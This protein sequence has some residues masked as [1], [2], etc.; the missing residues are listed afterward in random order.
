MTTR[1]GRNVCQDLADLSGRSVHGVDANRLRSRYARAVEERQAKEAE[2]ENEFRLNVP[3]VARVQKLIAERLEAEASEVNAKLPVASVYDA[4]MRVKGHAGRDKDAGL[5]ALHGHLERMW[6]K[7]RTGSITAEQYLILHD[8]YKRNFPRSAA[9]AVIEQIGQEGYTTLPLS[10]L[11]R[12]ASD[13]HT[14]EDFDRAMVYHGLNGPLPHQVK[15]RRFVLGLINEVDSGERYLLEGMD[16]G[17]S[18]CGEDGD[19][20]GRPFEGDAPVPQQRVRT[21]GPKARKRAQQTPA[22]DSTAVARVG[23]DTYLSLNDDPVYV[24]V[25]HDSSSFT[26]SS[27]VW[28]QQ[29]WGSEDEALQEAFAEL[30]DWDSERLSPEEMDERWKTE[31]REGYD[32]LTEAYDGFAFTTTAAE[33]RQMIEGI[34]NSYNREKFL[35]IE[36]EDNEDDEEGERPFEEGPSASRQ[37]RG[38]EEWSQL[39][40]GFNS[41]NYDAAYRGGTWEEGLAAENREDADD[42]AYRAAYI[43]AFIPGSSDSWMWDEDYMDAWDE[44]GTRLQG[45]GVAVDDPYEAQREEDG[46]PGREAQAG[47]DSFT[48]GY[49]EAAIWS[50]T[51]ESDDSGGRPLDENYGPEDLSPEALTKMADDCRR[52]Q[53]ENREDLESYASLLGHGPDWSGDEMWSAQAG[54]DFWLTR[55]GHGAGF[56]DR[57]VGEVGERLSRAAQLF[58]EQY[59]YVGDDGKLYVM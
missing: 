30:E 20:A 32:P 42:P 27:A 49:I 1:Y 14:Q 50:S 36:F 13:I 45:L 11:T 37:A 15:S 26:P 47:V 41:G 9:A 29:G 38:D 39:S 12:I 7:N 6:K 21:T 10:D 23:G 25:V 53:S 34:Q 19:E 48:E 8:H 44:Y 40:K 59:L 46:V 17:P 54:H 22:F 57:D 28:I 18:F 43:L 4:F 5:R 24:G 33:L 56:W 55:N 2:Y 3:H 52:F 51:D 16:F 31:E 35:G 58:G